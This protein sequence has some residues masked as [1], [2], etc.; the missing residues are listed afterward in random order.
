MRLLKLSEIEQRGCRFCADEIRKNRN[1]CPYEECPYH[2][3][4]NVKTYGEYMQKTN[5]R[6]LA[7]VLAELTK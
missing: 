6:G 1:M 7:R 4:D 2:E 5:T 3:L